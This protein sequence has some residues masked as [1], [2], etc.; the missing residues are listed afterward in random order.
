MVL[1]PGR[2]LTPFSYM[3]RA[4]YLKIYNL[5]SVRTLT[6]SLERLQ[7]INIALLCTLLIFIFNHIP[8][9]LTLL[10][11]CFC[12]LPFCYSF[13]FIPIRLWWLLL[14]APLAPHHWHNWPADNKSDL[15]A[16]L[17]VCHFHTVL[18]LL[19]EELMLIF[20]PVSTFGRS[21][22]FRML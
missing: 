7:F 6:L 18:I 14:L 1:R 11:A 12:K 22:K 15:D 9:K 13:S 21:V 2:R 5:T 17:T 4:S 10:T 20:A 3:A 19:Q 16:V 8:L